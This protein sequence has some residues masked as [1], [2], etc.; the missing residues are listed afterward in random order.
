VGFYEDLF[1][2]VRGLPP[3]LIQ[4]RN[5]FQISIPLIKS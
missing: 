5:P 3:V 1:G 4:T 2:L